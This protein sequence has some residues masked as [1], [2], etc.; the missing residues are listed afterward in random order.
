[1]S[2]GTARTLL[3]AAT[4]AAASA[5]GCAPATS[6]PV[7]IAPAVRAEVLAAVDRLFAAMRTRDTAAIRAM[8]H[9]ELRLFV[10]GGTEEAPTLRVSSLDQ[11]IA[12]IAAATARLDERAYDAE[13]RVDGN[14]ATVWTYYDFRRDDAFSHCGYDAFHFARGAE[15]WRI[16]GLAYTTRQ[17]DCS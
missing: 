16:I 12:S 9:P 8:A 4:L 1:M 3:L 6:A 10:P 7:T 13:V 5:Q 15:G 11:F 14:L 2:R 17:H